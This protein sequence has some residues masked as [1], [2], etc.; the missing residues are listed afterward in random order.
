MGSQKTFL[1][2]RCEGFLGKRLLVVR[3]LCSP[4]GRNLLQ[5]HWLSDAQEECALDPR[6]THFVLSLDRD[7]DN[8]EDI[9]SLAI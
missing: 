2:N 8:L 9:I 1:E 6:V 7:Q 5:V 4:S 3:L